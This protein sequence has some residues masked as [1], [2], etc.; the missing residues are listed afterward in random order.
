MVKAD[1]SWI[2][3]QEPAQH[4]PSLN[5]TSSMLPY[6]PQNTFPSCMDPC[7]STATLAFPGFPISALHEVRTVQANGGHEVSPRLPSLEN[8]S[9]SIPNPYLK[10]FQPSFAQGLGINPTPNDFTGC[11]QKSFLIFDQSWNQTRMFFSPLIP[12]SANHF[13]G[14]TKLPFACSLFEKSITQNLFDKNCVIGEGSEVRED[15]EEINALLFSDD[16]DGEYDDDD[17]EDDEV[18]STGQS[19]VSLKRSDGGIEQVEENSED[20]ATF[21]SSTKRRKLLDGGYHRS[22]VQTALTSVKLD[23]SCDNENDA[24]SCCVSPS[25]RTQYKDIDFSLDK[26]QWRRDQIRETLETIARII[27][28]S[29]HKDPLL[30]IDEAIN[31]LKSLKLKAKALGVC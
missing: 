12:S 16:E 28:G 27:P 11:T 17:G 30:I 3:Q 7:G 31:Y 19:P 8:S 29:N 1:E 13:I 25:A 26:K 9:L 20:F 22:L 23:I 18:T 6:G 10:E 14:T 24:Q 21:D 15:T 5:L 4:S 2:F